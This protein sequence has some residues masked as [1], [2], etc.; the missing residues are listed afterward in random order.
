MKDQSIPKVS[1]IVIAYNIQN[2]IGKCIKS[3][4]KQTYKDFELI[5]V[6]DG[7]TDNTLKTIQK[8]EPGNPQIKVIDQKNMGGGEARMNGLK[9][10]SGEWIMFVDGDDWIS[11]NAI[12]ILYK[13]AIEKDADIVSTE[14]IRVLDKFGIIKTKQGNS[15]SAIVDHDT[16]MDKY[17]M[18]FLGI[19]IFNVG[20]CTK[21]YKK[22]ILIESG[23]KA[24]GIGPEDLYLNINV[25]PYAKRVAFIEDR[26]Y[27]YRFGGM[28]NR[29]NPKWMSDAV[30]LYKLKKEKINQYNLTKSTLY[31]RIELLNCVKTH[32]RQLIKYN[33]YD[34]KSIINEI[35]QIVKSEE[36]QESIDI[37]NLSTICDTDPFIAA[38]CKHDYETMYEISLKHVKSH[39]W[40]D[41]IKMVIS[42]LLT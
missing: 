27:F 6:N 19:N 13:N 17:Y 39:K 29:Y 21:I 12:E 35:E 37:K 5:I 40:K 9:K 36:Y 23:V 34:K 25:F 3:I 8:Y 32:I 22:S 31:I 41:N 42:K 28:T 26:F 14:L 10:A 4:L 33:I 2:V 30:V 18:G 7:S 1:I 11:E 24:I 15:F 38:S 16:V 20:V